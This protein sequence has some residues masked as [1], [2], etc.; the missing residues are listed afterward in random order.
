MS[1][2]IACF[3]LRCARPPKFEARNRSTLAEGEA[4]PCRGYPDDPVTAR[5][6]TG[7]ARYRHD[8]AGGGVAGA[9]TT[10]PAGESVLSRR[11]GSR[12]AGPPR[13]GNQA[14][15]RTQA[16]TG[17]K[18]PAEA[19]GGFAGGGAGVRRLAVSR[20][21]RCRAGI[22]SPPDPHRN[23]LLSCCYGAPPTCWGR[24]RSPTARGQP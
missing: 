22:L 18:Y 14:A 10:G 1:F 16:R 13:P 23:R 20:R 12:A 15:P 8:D 17:S 21:D 19:A 24:W 4:G 6:D 9:V 3:D 2:R 7:R 5:R 11:A